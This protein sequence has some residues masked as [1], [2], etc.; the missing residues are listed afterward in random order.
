MLF[1]LEKPPPNFHAIGF[2]IETGA[3]E[4]VRGCFARL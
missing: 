2:E 3:G 4:R 1:I